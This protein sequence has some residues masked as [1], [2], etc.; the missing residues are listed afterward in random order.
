[1]KHRPILNT[2]RVDGPH[3]LASLPARLSDLSRHLSLFLQIPPKAEVSFWIAIVV[4]LLVVG[5]HDNEVERERL[6]RKPPVPASRGGV[7]DDGDLLHLDF[8][9]GEL[10][11]GE[12]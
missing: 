1:M 6:T 11:P 9:V 3:P 5:L 8:V 10:F 4:L 7:G 2:R 12:L